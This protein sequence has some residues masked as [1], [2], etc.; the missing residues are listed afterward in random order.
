MNKK[1]LSVAVLA[2]LAA[3]LTANAGA[4]VYGAMHVAVERTT[5]G[6]ADATYALDGRSRKASKLGLKGSTDTSLMDFKTVY[7]FEMGLDQNKGAKGS[8]YQRDTWV[9]L[10]SKS[11]GTVRAGTIK[12]AWKATSS[13]VDPLFT[14]A[15]E[16]RGFLG[17]TSA[18][19]AGGTGDGRGRSTRTIRYDSPTIA[20]AKIL[21]DYNFSVEGENNIGLG[22]RYKIGGLKVFADYKSIGKGN[23]V[24]G[25]AKAGTATKVG[26]K[27]SS[28]AIGASFQYEKDSGAVTGSTTKTQDNLFAN[29]TYSMGATTFIVTAGQQSDSSSGADDGRKS[30]AFVVS[31]KVAKKVSLYTGYG[32]YAG[33]VNTSTFTK[34]ANG[35]TIKA[36]AMSAFV[37]GIKAGY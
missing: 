2:V 35:D 9:G 32:A 3:P 25:G 10:S 19:Q 22:L 18:K 7:K 23:F 37:V 30:Y 12:T 1:L 21:A 6:D 26:A 34:D 33:G 27:F 14:T 20:G 5:V 16:G 29:V 13:M 15:F 17:L 4:K 36:D 28:G 8:Y 11:M 31:Q 24:D